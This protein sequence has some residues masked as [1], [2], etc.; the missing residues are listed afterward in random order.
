[1]ANKTDLCDDEAS[2]DSDEVL[3]AADQLEANVEDAEEDGTS[4]DSTPPRRSPTSTRQVSRSEA[5]ALAKAE[6]LLYVE[7]SAK[8][9]TGVEEAFS[10]TAR[11]VLHRMH[12]DEGKKTSKQVGS[13]LSTTCTETDR[14]VGT[15]GILRGCTT[16]SW[17][18]RTLC[19]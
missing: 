17:G 6:G 9:G 16:L 3:P 15:H 10:R 7:T 8:D 14:P 12:G 19:G 2:D 13:C 5:V 4:P 18:R 1:V 11:E